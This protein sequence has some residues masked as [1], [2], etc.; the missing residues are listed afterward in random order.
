MTTSGAVSS[1]HVIGPYVTA[2]LET[3]QRSGL[4]VEQLCARM[5]KSRDWLQPLPYQIG[6]ADYLALMAE[7]AC[8]NSHFGL[9]VGAAVKPNTYPVLGYTAMSCATIAQVLQQVV[10]FEGINHD[11]GRSEIGEQEGMVYYRWHANPLFVPDT[12][13]GIYSQLVSSVFSGLIN[14]SHYLVTD[15]LPLVRMEFAFAVP[16]DTN[17]YEELFGC[18]LLYDQPHNTLWVDREILDWPVCNAD[19]MTFAALSRHAE[20]L[21][22]QQYS[23]QQQTIVERLRRALLDMLRSQLVGIEPVS[24]RLNMSARTL[25]RK[26]KEEGTTYQN[27]LDHIRR[28]LAESYL[29]HSRLSVSE[30]AFLL[31]Y[32][33]Q[34]SFNHAFREWLGMSPGAYRQSRHLQADRPRPGG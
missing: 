13:H 6:V 22:E 14:F 15:P 20:L 27:E 25:Q 16:E 2:L 28:E 12:G 17:P 21:Q 32:Q 3:A 18:P 8:V 31:G 10:R 5:G 11:L 34:S 7:G 30:I 4:S 24:Q 29:G 1:G 23:Y 9:D 33:E 26:L 19:D